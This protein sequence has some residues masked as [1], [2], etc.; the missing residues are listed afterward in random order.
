MGTGLKNGTNRSHA[1]AMTLACFILAWL[2]ADSCGAAQD[3]QQTSAATADFY[4]SPDGQD[5]NSGS[6]TSPFA[7]LARARDAVRQL[8]AAGLTKNILVLIRA[9]VYHERETLTFGPA[10]SGTA[11]YS[12]TYASYP[13]DRVEL[14]GGQEIT[15]WKRGVGDVWTAEVPEVKAGQCV[16]RQLFV[17]GR[18]AIRARTPNADDQKPWWIIRNT[19]MTENEDQTYTVTVSGPIRTY[20]NPDDVE[21]VSIYNNEGGR[22]RLEAVNVSEHALVVAPPHKLNSKVFG[23]DWYLSAPTVGKACYLENALE[24][25]DQ[26]GEWYLDRRTGILSYWPRPGEN[27]LQ[28]KVIAP[29]VQGTLLK[30]A[31]TPEKPVVNLTF[32][33][34]H[35]AHVD[36][37]LPPWG[38]NGLFSCN[39]ATGSK[40]KPGHRFIEA[41]VEF[42][43]ARSCHFIDGSI[44]HAGGMALCL[45]GGTAF[46]R[47][48]GNE[49]WDVGGGGIGA[50]GCNVAGG[51]LHAAPPPEPDEYNEYRI[52]NNY[53]HHCGIDYYGGSGICLYLA[54]NSSVSHN[55]VHD[56]AY[57]GILVAGSQDPGVPFARNNVV[58]FNHIYNCMKVAV[59]GAGL[60]VTFA[61]YDRGTLVRG[62][63]VH[64]TQWNAFGRGEVAGGILETIPCH[65]LYLDGNNTGCRYAD[66]VVYRNAGGPLLFN[67]HVSRNQ[68]TDNF[69]QKDGAPPYEFIE[70]M[71]AWAGLE[72]AFRQSILKTRPNPCE[73][74]SLTESAHA[75]LWAAHQLD[76][77]GTGRGVVQ[78]VRR[79][80]GAPETFHLP[81]RGVNMAA[82]YKLKAY[83]GILAP[84]DARFFEGTFFGNCDPSLFTTYMT[85]LG[86]LPILS[87]VAPVALE[88]GSEVSGQ[89]L[90]E[91]GLPVKLDTTPRVLWIAYCIAKKGTC[92]SP[93]K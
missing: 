58:E 13:E 54:Q 52:A 23:N 93:E 32:K 65:G 30:V 84:A 43:Y 17:N 79:K 73:F 53:I 69:F 37:P 6:A 74:H 83:A 3:T 67:S 66:N 5:A 64:D 29:V 15:G 68:W 39:V 56:I 86:D 33:G 50:G 48:E 44:A 51:Y 77:P 21:L 45:R 57:G 62:N 42:E 89:E 28:A 72:S 24:M 27:L 7:T 25:L 11:E 40:D 63:L 90:V 78:I 16:F 55:L 85:T 34:I 91:P 46:N 1:L 4:V 35:A 88:T 31:G 92:E 87:E 81:L 18:R 14:S 47:I 80:S 70:A 76:L 75:D 20:S 59:D 2:A 41:A 9:G 22:K 61:N 19:T 12:I 49:I 10:D 26:P 38:Y 36:W 71:Q 82:Q 60:Y 8:V